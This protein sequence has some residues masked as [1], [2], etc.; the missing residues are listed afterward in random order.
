MTAKL[1]PAAYSPTQIILH[2]AIAA[3][4]LWE[5]FISDD[6]GRDGASGFLEQSHVWSGIGILALVVARI[7]LRVF[8][9]VP[10]PVETNELQALAADIAHLLFYLLLVYMPVTGLLTYYGGLPLGGVHELGEPV[11]IVL[12]AVHILATAWHQFVKRDNIMRRMGFSS[13]G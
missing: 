12:I 7:A 11:F 10:P 3:L 4:V 8:R 5:L 6:P 2:W 9:G 1:R 13:A